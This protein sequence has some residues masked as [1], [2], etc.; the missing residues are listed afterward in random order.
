MDNEDKKNLF[1]AYDASQ[2]RFE[3]FNKRLW[4][5]CIILIIALVGTN[6]CWIYYES[7]W[8]YSESTNVTQDV[9]ANESDAMIIGIGDIYDK[10]KANCNKN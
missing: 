3:R 5:L 4:I 9:K 6:G 7:Q 1:F 8:Q 10:G 2:A